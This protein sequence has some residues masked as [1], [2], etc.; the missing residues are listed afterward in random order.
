MDSMANSKVG[1]IAFPLAAGL[2][3]STSPYAARGI[4]TGLGVA[5]RQAMMREQQQADMEKRRLGEMFAE[6]IGM[7]DYRS[8]DSTASEPRPGYDRL[9]GMAQTAL[10]MGDL[11]A[12]LRSIVEME[13]LSSNE[14]MQ[15]HVIDNHLVDPSGK[16]LGSVPVS[17]PFDIKGGYLYD[18][19]K[20]NPQEL[21]ST[22]A[23]IA[24]ENSLAESEIGVDQS[25]VGANQ[26][27]ARQRAAVAEHTVA[28]TDKLVSQGAGSAGADPNDLQALRNSLLQEMK[29]LSA[30]PAL[31][32]AAIEQLG[33]KL[34]ALDEVLNPRLGLAVP[35]Q[36]QPKE[37]IQVQRLQQFQP[38]QQIQGGTEYVFNPATGKIEPKG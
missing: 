19:T 5:N 33:N 24:R 14:R 26:A 13:K 27:L 2:G 9:I 35:Q 1:Q 4:V 29:I 11:D 34:K 6:Q 22:T 25:R 28:K 12:G 20:G 38:P 10:R 7:P 30:N 31:N 17:E 23:E 8:A 15:R 36:E 3:A 18:K 21:S 16:V 37:R 32:A